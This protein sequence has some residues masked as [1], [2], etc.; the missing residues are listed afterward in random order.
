MFSSKAWTRFSILSQISLPQRLLQFFWHGILDQVLPLEK[1]QGF[2]GTIG[3]FGR[4]GRIS[5]KVQETG[6]FKTH[7]QRQPDTHIK[8]QSSIKPFFLLS[9]PAIGP[10]SFRTTWTLHF[11]AIQP[12][13][14]TYRMKL[15]HMQFK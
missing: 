15:V 10:A 7:F 8:I 13:V 11:E 12:I 4:D 3:S 2:P 1:P 6:I 9:F 14:R 5:K